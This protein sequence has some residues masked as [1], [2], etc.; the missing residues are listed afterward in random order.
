[1]DDK[2]LRAAIEAELVNGFKGWDFS[3][4]TRNGRMQEFPLDWNYETELAPWLKSAGTLL[5][6]G[7]GGGEFLSRLSGKPERTCATE[8]YEPNVPLAQARLGPLGIEVRPSQNDLIPF[9]DGSFDLV[10]NRHESYLP[11]EVRRVLKTGGVYVTQQVGGMNDADINMR[12]GAAPSEFASWSLAAALEGLEKEEFSI[13][14]SREC[15]TKTRFFDIGAVAWYLRCIP[16]QVTDFGV[17]KYFGRLRLMAAVI[18][19]TGYIDFLTHRF[20]IA[21]RK[22]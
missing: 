13:L 21:A 6:L 11:A 12:L 19:E 18:E 17:E 7:T 4:I 8:G 22:G 16:W 1:M 2:T 14:K 9:G 3:R 15:M 5:D 20:L 10:I